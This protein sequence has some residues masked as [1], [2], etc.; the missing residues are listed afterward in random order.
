MHLSFHFQGLRAGELLESFDRVNRV[1]FFLLN[2]SGAL[3]DPTMAGEAWE[4][5]FKLSEHIK[6][7]GWV[8][9][10][11]Q[12]VATLSWRQELVWLL[13]LILWLVLLL[14]GYWWEI[15]DW[16]NVDDEGNV[17][18]RS[19]TRSSM[20]WDTGSTIARKRGSFFCYYWRSTELCCNWE[21]EKYYHQSSNARAKLSYLIHY[22]CK[23][24]QGKYNWSQTKYRGLIIQSPIFFVHWSNRIMKWWTPL[25]HSQYFPWFDWFFMIRLVPISVFLCQ[26]I[27]LPGFSLAFF[28]F[29]KNWTPNWSKNDFLL[30][31]K[32]PLPLVLSIQMG[33]V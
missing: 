21:S 1:T 5:K 11:V 16:S 24:R 23:H 14:A 22:R 15:I 31:Y 2:V 9:R 19:A 25:L 12:W 18:S 7:A 17:F 13:L 29:T 33:S 27:W 4:C 8:T 20:G 26:R 30:K 28:F 3:R 6:T 32:P 10:L